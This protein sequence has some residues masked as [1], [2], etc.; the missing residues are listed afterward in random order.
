MKQVWVL[1]TFGVNSIGDIYGVFS[2]KE[3]VTNYYLAHQPLDGDGYH[4]VFIDCHTI[5]DSRKITD[6]QLGS[7]VI[8]VGTC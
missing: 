4:D 5:D 8:H 1:Y 7:S 3:E 6:K 2:S